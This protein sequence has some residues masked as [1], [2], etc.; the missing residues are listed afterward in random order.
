[1]LENEGKRL[2]EKPSI[3]VFLV[4]RHFIEK[5]LFHVARGKGSNVR[6]DD[7][8][9]VRIYAI[10]TD[11]KRV[12]EKAKQMRLDDPETNRY[13][14]V[15]EINEQTMGPK[16]VFDVKEDGTFHI[17]PDIQKSLFNTKFF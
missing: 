6:L 1:M 13:Y 10:S 4:E 9:W 7:E 3:W 17:R 8:D 11:Q 12:F 5:N 15:Y 14:R 2:G 16:T